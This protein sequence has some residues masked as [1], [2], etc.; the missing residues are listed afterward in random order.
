MKTKRPTNV[1]SHVHGIFRSSYC[2]CFTSVAVEETMFLCFII[3]IPAWMQI[4]WSLEKSQAGHSSSSIF[5]STETDTHN[6]DTEI[7]YIMF[8]S[9]KGHTSYFPALLCQNGNFQ[10]VMFLLFP[11]NICWTDLIKPYNLKDGSS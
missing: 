11:L 5:M 4:I 7:C 6:H 1:L 8:R 9:A 10:V 2:E 3:Y